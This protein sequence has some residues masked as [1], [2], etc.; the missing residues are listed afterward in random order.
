MVQ[1]FSLS[2]PQLLIIFGDLINFKYLNQPKLQDYEHF[3]IVD[4]VFLCLQYVSSHTFYLMA[5]MP[6]DS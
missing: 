1:I 4:T 3:Q 5:Y 6:C 2:E